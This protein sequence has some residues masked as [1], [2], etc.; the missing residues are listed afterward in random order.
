M[1][2]SLVYA[3]FEDWVTEHIKR[4]QMVANLKKKKEKK[5]N[6]QKIDFFPSFVL[7]ESTSL[8]FS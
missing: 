5:Q 1:H 3:H 2:K 7:S 8:L 4:T 6:E